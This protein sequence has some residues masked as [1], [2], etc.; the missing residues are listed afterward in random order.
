M[1][2]ALSF[3][4]PFI[5]AALAALPLIWLL[6]RATPP[7]PKRERFPAFIILRQLQSAEETPDRTP[8]WLLLMR[9]LLMALIIVALA[10]PVLNA[11]ARGPQTGPLVLVIDNSWIAAQQWAARRD[12]MR[13]AA[14]EA[15]QGN[16][17]AFLIVTAPEDTQTVLQPMTGE[18]LRAAADALE[19][20]PFR[21]DRQSATAKLSELDTF[22]T[23]APAAEIRWLSDG[24]A[25]ESDAAF[26][27][28]LSSRGSLTVYND[29]AA[30][31]FILRPS[32]GG[33]SN[34]VVAVER[35]QAGPEYEGAL[36]ATARDG[37]ELA[38]ADF[39]IAEGETRAE[40][41]IDLP[42][43]LRNELS[44]V[45]I[46]N[47]A[48]A[49]AVYLADARDRR[50]LIGLVTESENIGSNLLS[51]FHYVRQ[52][53][54]QHAAFLDGEL[55][56]ILNSD[57]SVIMLDDV[58]RLR[59]SEA[60]ALQSWVQRGG[61][62]IRFAGPVLAEASQDGTPQLTPVTL[63]GGGRAFG[64]ALTWDTPQKLDALPQEGPF[65]GLTPPD[66]VVVR[67]QVLAEPGGET[68]ART[69]ARLEDGTPLVTGMRE[70]EGVIA[71][72][73][74]TATPE[75]S[76]L[77]ISSLFIEMLRRLTFLSELGPETATDETETRYAPYRLL[78]GE[79]RFTRPGDSAQALTADKLSQAPS[80]DYRPGLYGA[81]E[82][83]L[84][85]NAVNADTPFEPISLP[86]V[87]MQPYAAEP[88]VSL[89][90][91]LIVAAL[92]LLLLDGA[93]ALFMSGKISFRRTR[94]ATLAGALMLAPVFA[95]D[96]SA[97]AQ[98]LDPEIDPVAAD[99]ALSTRLAYVE[100]GDPAIDQLSE[101]GLAALSRELVR[102]TAIEPAPPASIDLNT[103]DL[104]VYSFLY[105]PIT[106]GAESPTD[107]ALGNIENFMR[108]GG[109]LLIDTRDDER[110]IGAGSTP[111]GEALQ[112]ILSQLNIPALAPV[113]DDHVLMRS[114]YLLRS[115]TGRMNN[116]PV[117]V[118][119]DT[120][121]AND[122]VTAVIIG[123]RDWAGAWAS[124]NFGRP[125]RSMGPGGPRA[126]EF[127][128]R[129]GVNMVMVAFT[130]NYKSD[131]VHTP[132]L[133]ERLGE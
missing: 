55:A 15:D 34:P 82:T 74:V 91:P 10:G 102:R 61:V 123:G 98:P 45:R 114:F 1:L 93:L 47:T 105:W 14:A 25:G 78:T 73:H 92:L 64:G 70:G 88:P 33:A 109:L 97:M 31:K 23:S 9:L 84:A 36:I 69:W 32:E 22:L 27:E 111:E 42:L 16:R 106:A 65:A 125:A 6:L 115:L 112:R 85:L 46:A 2:S 50:A 44:T 77:P 90:P 87:N 95:P 103:D 39:A 51:G 119:A 26:V 49:G 17:Q 79:G 38:R 43:A 68:T 48:S 124:D 107:A 127:A 28:N 72:F 66:D 89:A 60:N 57:A 81:P 100:T 104:S 83:P 71:L 121:G 21:T 4:S 3:T 63:R 53:L 128:Y 41:V 120:S 96:N 116:N 122:G 117:W 132:I 118:E 86:G 131:Q 99:A 126:R 58:G 13:E 101:Q 24:A 52:A 113:D 29:R 67:R 30:P 54:D 62:L 5:L 80:P 76:D 35:L 129:S 7:S 59:A 37:R 110:S 94:M 56:D 75:W 18:G 11:P 133:L 19:A 12:A 108:F 40:A 130:G 20:S 8:W